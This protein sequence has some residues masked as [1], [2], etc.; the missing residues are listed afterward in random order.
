MTIVVLG[1]YSHVVVCICTSAKCCKN[2]KALWSS[3]MQSTDKTKR[4]KRHVWC[5]SAA[6]KYL[7]FSSSSPPQAKIADRV[8]DIK[9]SVAISAALTNKSS[10]CGI[11]TAA[12]K[13]LRSHSHHTLA[14]DSQATLYAYLLH[15]LYMHTGSV[16]IATC[17]IVQ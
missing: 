1:N 2:I 8:I 6:D 5:N 11:Q 12:I 14:T 16:A 10:V 13:I 4:V 9:I 3:A 15:A 7:Y 17:V